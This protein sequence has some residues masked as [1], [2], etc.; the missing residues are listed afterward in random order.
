VAGAHLAA[1][2]LGALEIKL[3]PMLLHERKR[4]IV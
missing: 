1:G 3:A 4:L 2:H